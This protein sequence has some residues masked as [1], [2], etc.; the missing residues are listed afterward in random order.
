LLTPHF[1]KKCIPPDGI[2]FNGGA[3][4]LC[5]VLDFNL[6]GWIDLIVMIEGSYPKERLIDD[7]N[8][9]NIDP[10][11]R[12]ELNRLGKWAFVFAEPNMLTGQHLLSDYYLIRYHMCG[13][14]SPYC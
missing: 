12:L 1:D 3:L 14:A 10:A 4:R 9:G 11:I 13:N 5:S 7:V 8:S 6:A 2:L